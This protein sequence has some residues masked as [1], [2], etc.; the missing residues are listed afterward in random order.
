VGERSLARPW[1]AAAALGV[2]ALGG[3]GFA[4]TRAGAEPPPGVYGH[5]VAAAF[6]DGAPARVTGGFGEDS[7]FACHWEGQENDG[8]G[9]LVIE[10]VP[11]RYEPGEPYELAIEISRPGMTLGGFQLAA[12]MAADTLQAG[13]F[14]VRDADAGRVAV[15]TDR[16][17][18]FVQHTEAGTALSGEDR[19]R[20]RVNWTAP[21]SGRVVFHVS[22]VAG[23]GDRSQM[24]DHVYTLAAGSVSTRP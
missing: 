13:T 23:D 16:G 20:W 12:R 22:A 5:S 14:S 2:L 1:I 9:R 7:C 21:E 6:P 15:V 10:G 18:Q 19:V 17:V 11:E 8:V 3:L 24:G 4:G